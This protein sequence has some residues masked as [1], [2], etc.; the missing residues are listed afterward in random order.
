MATR[1]DIRETKFPW[2]TFEINGELYAV[3]SESLTTIVNKPEDSAYV[4]NVSDFIVGL[5]HIRGNVVPLIDLKT[6]FKMEHDDNDESTKMV[7]VIENENSFVGIVVGAVKSVE[8]L[9]ILNE[10]DEVKK[11]N[12]NGYIRGIA[13]SSKNE[14]TVLIIDEEK[15]INAL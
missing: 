1:L 13:K 12:D 8:T 5:I 6:L 14:G 15:V 9:E 3:N 4:P 11:M 7:M 2:V 10:S